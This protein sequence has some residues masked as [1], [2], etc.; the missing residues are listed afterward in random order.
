MKTAL[1]AHAVQHANGADAPVVSCHHVA[2]ARG[3]FVTLGLLGREAYGHHDSCSGDLDL[4]GGCDAAEDAMTWLSRLFAGSQ[5]APAA[6]PTAAPARP[7][8]KS[9]AERRTYVL[10]GTVS[11]AEFTSDY[12][13]YP[14]N[15]TTDSDCYDALV[16]SWIADRP[17]RCQTVYLRRDPTNPAGVLVQR[18]PA[19]TIGRLS[20]IDAPLYRGLIAALAGLGLASTASAKTI[21]GTGARQRLRLALSLDSPQ[22]IAA[23]FEIPQNEIVW[24]GSLES[25]ASLATPRRTKAHSQ[26]SESLPADHPRFIGVVGESHYQ[27][28]LRQMLASAPRA[29]VTIE[30]EPTNPQDKN[31]VRIA[32]EAGE[33]IGYLAKGH[34]TQLK[35]IARARP[36]QCWAELRGGTPDKPSVGIVLDLGDSFAAGP[37]V[38]A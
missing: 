9:A 15:V 6:T 13:S 35:Q 30:G 2:A 19:T 32:N 20:P 10:S 27:D 34:Y 12:D 31:A 3:S 24:Q 26:S 17:E 28:V 23:D 21:G 5:K 37:D 7:K 8:V 38:D 36:V 18:S 11:C 22:H 4:G 16:A 1:I 29:S 14:V 33:T 25:V